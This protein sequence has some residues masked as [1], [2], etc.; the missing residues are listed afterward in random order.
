[1][2]RLERCVGIVQSLSNGL[3][4]REANDALTANVRNTHTLSVLLYIC[5]YQQNITNSHLQHMFY[6]LMFVCG[7]L[8]MLSYTLH[9][10]VCYCIT[11]L[12]M[13]VQHLETK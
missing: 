4:E 10:V 3:S 5:D 13:L 6:M 1:M 2:Q 9:Y 11:I 12:L 7:N 8:Y